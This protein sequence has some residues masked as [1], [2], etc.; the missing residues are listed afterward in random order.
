[1]RGALRFAQQLFSNNYFRVYT[2][3]DII[4]VEIG[5]AVK[6]II[7]IAAGIIDGL[8]LGDN[9][10]G[11]LLTRGIAEIKRLGCALGANPETFLGL[12]GIGDMITTATS[13]HSRNRYVGYELG[14]GKKLNQILGR[15][16]MVAEGVTTTKAIYD[17]KNKLSIQMPITDKVYQV[18]FEGESPEKAIKELMSRQ[19][20]SED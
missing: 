10:K 7:A 17:L 20:K 13:S 19:L 14:S 18:L 8:G 9:T 12:A 6:N 2:S 4:G 3:S 15:M 11:A 1:M 16:K 5:G